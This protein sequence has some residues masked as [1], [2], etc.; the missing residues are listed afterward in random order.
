MLQT[1]SP[2]QMRVSDLETISSRRLL[3]FEVARLTQSESLQA[4]RIAQRE[5]RIDEIVS[6]YQAALALRRA[7]E[8]NLKFQI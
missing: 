1:C 8:P 7:A 3:P 5:F 2:L 6:L 4:D